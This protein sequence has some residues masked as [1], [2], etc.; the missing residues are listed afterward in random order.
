MRYLGIDPGG[1]RIGLAVA[2]DETRVATPLQVIAYH[3][4]KRA[5]RVIAE[6][7]R[8]QHAARVVIGLPTDPDGGETAACKRS[9]A[10]AATLRELG[11]D[12]VFQSEY[13]TSDEARRRARASGRHPRQPVDDLAALVILEEYLGRRA[14]ETKIDS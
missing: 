11:I 7:A 13:L 12:V 9:H 10:L 5:A 1:K 3:D 8:C 14:T 4:R 6:T 2:D